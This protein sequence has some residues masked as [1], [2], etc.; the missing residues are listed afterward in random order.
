MKKTFSVVIAVLMI[1]IG[2]GVAIA[3]TEAEKQAAID[4]GLAYLDSTKT[5]DGAGGY[6]WNTT[7][8]ADADTGSVLLAFAEQKSKPLGW[9]GKDYT[10]LV[11]GAAKYLLKTA[12]SIDISSGPWF[13]PAAPGKTG[14]IWGGGES[15]YVSGLVLPALS[16]YAQVVAGTGTTIASSNAA[17]NGQTYGQV[18]QKVVDMFVWGQNGPASGTADGGWRYTPRTGQSDNS[19][20]QWPVIG[21]TFAQAAGATVPS[22]TKAEL[23]KWIAYIQNGT[24]GGAGY[25][26]PTYLVNVAK[27]GGLLVEMAFSGYNGAGPYPKDKAGAL[28]YLNGQWLT[29]ANSTWDGNFEQPYAMWSTYKGL[30]ST[31]GLADTTA[32]TNLHAAGTIDAGD[33]WNWWEDYCD[34]LVKNQLAGGN[35]SGYVYWNGP[36]EA[37]WFINILN[38]TEVGPPVGTPEPMTLVLLAA[39]ILGLGIFRKYR[40]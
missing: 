7:G 24:S 28:A 10:A 22:Q 17:V 20:A 15:T 3:A 38:A 31:I 1:G 6:Y 11:D 32:I 23:Q 34:W 39:G 27:T 25:D 18:L 35:W 14:L 13:G 19:T 21:M 30:A 2:C 8:Y 12:G 36:I 26:S 29:T 33:T 40:D 16:R 37:A 4:K 9:N 5:S